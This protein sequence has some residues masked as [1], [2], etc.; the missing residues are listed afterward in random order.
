MRQTVRY[1]VASA[2]ADSRRAYVCPLPYVALIN[3]VWMGGGVGISYGAK[4]KV[5]RSIQFIHLIASGRNGEGCV[6]YARGVHLISSVH[7]LGCS[8]VRRLASASFRMYRAGS[9][10]VYAAS[11]HS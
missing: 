2:K 7:L 8:P 3:G 10:A 6:R 4:W 11:G 9:A 1:K 5:K